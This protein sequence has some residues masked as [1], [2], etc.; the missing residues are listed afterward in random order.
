MRGMK[1][2]QTASVINRDRAGAAFNA[3][4]AAI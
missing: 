2:N 3:L 4:A 1:T